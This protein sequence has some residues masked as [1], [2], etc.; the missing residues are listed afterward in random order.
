MNY[1]YKNIETTT[2]NNV[3]TTSINNLFG[4]LAL[5]KLNKEK[6]LNKLISNLQKANNKNSKNLTL[7]FFKKDEEQFLNLKKK[8]DISEDLWSLIEAALD[9]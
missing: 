6:E 8:S 9:Y 5:K 4:L 3:K 2:R 7:A 1:T